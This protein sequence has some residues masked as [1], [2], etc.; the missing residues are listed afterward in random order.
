MK[1]DI[2]SILE[3]LYMIDP[4]LEKDE[5]NLK[6][7]IEQ[8]IQAKPDIAIDKQFA[9]GLR[10]QLMARADELKAS[11]PNLMTLV[12]RFIY[13]LA[14]GVL[15]T[16]LI[17][18]TLVYFRSPMIP[19]SNKGEVMSLSGMAER[20]G[21]AEEAPVVTFDVELEQEASYMIKQPA[22]AMVT[23]TR[24]ATP[25]PTADSAEVLPPKGAEWG[26]DAEMPEVTSAMAPM[27]MIA[28]DEPADAVVLEGVPDYRGQANELIAKTET[29]LEEKGDSISDELKEAITE[30]IDALKALLETEEGDTEAIQNAMEALE[31]EIEK[32][33]L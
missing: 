22:P 31:Q 11:K 14:G 4:G 13:P 23:K 2:Q 33:E 16:V 20:D 30:K 6:K 9:E 29:M 18:V 32:T 5:K 19:V 7:L 8:L 12:H 25:P 24:E 10:R 17:V 15:A 1:N 28:E 3:D 26:D 27:L 21:A